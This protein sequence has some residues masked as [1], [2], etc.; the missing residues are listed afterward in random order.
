VENE[1]GINLRIEVKVN[2]EGGK[3]TV[4]TSFVCDKGKCGK[5]IEVRSDGKN[6]THNVLCPEHG[7]LTSFPNE[8]A[9]RKFT[10][11][12]ANKILSA[13][14]HDLITEKTSYTAID[15]N[16]DPNSVN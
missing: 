3:Q 1:T 4:Q 10:V 8:A 6:T 11:D 5:E 7:L 16:P 14:G 12:A 13:H 9:L 15:D 2:T